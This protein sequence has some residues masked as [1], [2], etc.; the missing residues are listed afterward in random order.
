MPFET[1]NNKTIETSGISV[2]FFNQLVEFFEFNQGKNADSGETCQVFNFD[3][4][5]SEA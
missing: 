3:A 5:F 4:D 2:N 1:K